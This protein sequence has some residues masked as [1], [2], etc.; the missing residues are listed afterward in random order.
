MNT[1]REALERQAG[2]AGT[3]DL[4]IDELVGLGEHRL[5][6]RRLTAVVG[7]GLAVVLAIALAIGGTAWNR[8]ADHQQG[9][10]RRP[11]TTPGQ[12]HTPT[13][14]TPRPIVYSD[15]RVD[16]PRDLL[17]DPIH[18]GDRRVD[19]GS[20]WVHMDVVDGGL[21]YTTG[22]YQDDGR[23]W[24]TNGGAPEQIGSHACDVGRGAPGTVVTGN[25]GPLAAWLDCTREHQ[26]Q[27][28]VYDAGTGLEAAREPTPPECGN[29][30]AASSGYL[31]TECW[32]YAVIGDH[33]YLMQSTEHVREYQLDVA[34]GR[35]TKV[36]LDNPEGDP[37][38]PGTFGPVSQAY[39]DDIR[40]NP[41]GLVIGG[42]WDTGTPT[43]VGAFDIVGTQLVPASGNGRLTSAFDTATRR[44][45]H[46]HLPRGYQPDPDEA[47]TDEDFGLFEWLDD[48]TVALVRY[49]SGS[50]DQD[51]LTCPLSTG[52][53]ELAVPSRG[54]DR[55]FRVVQHEDLGR[56]D[57]SA[58]R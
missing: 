30:N 41:R 34:T 28:V 53:C 43:P 4:D 20:G 57:P 17:G 8:S 21:I 13:P 18:V 32:V 11:P 52:R 45:I 47:G 3:P 56:S 37:N 9:P 55:Y 7:A 1:L 35:I 51:I 6:R 5:R 24:F 12:T 58:P 54:R 25:S 33:V 29:S 50:H 14:D 40:S 15:V 36:T 22:G 44:P 31:S 42:S 16:E 2:R 48:E 27:L 19:T 38:V 39:L 49:S 23:V 10:I 46:L 26:P